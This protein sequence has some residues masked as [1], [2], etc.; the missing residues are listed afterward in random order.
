MDEKMKWSLAGL[1][2][3]P[4][5]MVLGNSM[6]I[7]VL[8]ALKN[9][10]GISQFEASLIITAFSIP[11]GIV[12][13]VAGYLS[14]HY[15]RKKVIVP[16]LL[17]YALGG[18]IAGLG[19]VILKENS[20]PVIMAGR[21]IQG[22]GAAGTAPIAMALASDIFTGAARSKALGVIEAFNGLGK[23]LSPILGSLIA[24][25]VWYAVFFAFPLLCIPFAIIV[26]MK[27]T[28]PS[29]NLNKQP[30]KQYLKGILKIFSKQG[31]TLLAAFLAGS[32]TLFILFGLLFYLSDILEEK[33]HIDGVYKGFVLAL[34]L[35]VMATTSYV[36]GKKVKS[37]PKK[38][39]S[40]A[41]TGLIVIA[42][43]S[44]AAIISTNTYFQM[45]ALMIIGFG[46]GLVLPCL[47]TIITGSISAEERGLVTSLYG[48]V[49]FFGVAIG[50]PVFG[51]L[52]KISSQIMFGAMSI[53]AGITAAI[54]FFVIKVKKSG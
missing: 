8:P 5:V 13:P 29:G 39:K 53:L 28:E 32:I 31:A 24:L 23:V 4:L 2:L 14:D 17:V 12:I 40:I 7:P 48:S 9:E 18:V 36:T 41:V 37:K 30:V 34:P 47:N 15:G 52:M 42:V 43:G 3:V 46:S 27:V 10:L 26:W 45:S 50:P 22:V 54:A 33:Y 38:M 16:A 11:A 19:A 6:L 49:R 51:F 35:L 20:Y 21:V 1:C 25:I 44:G